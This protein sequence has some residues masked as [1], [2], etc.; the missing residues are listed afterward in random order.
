MDV[1]IIGSGNVATV[2]GKMISKVHKVVHVCS[3]NPEHAAFLAGALHCAFSGLDNINNI[4]AD[5]FL[6]AV[7]DAAI[8]NMAHFHVHEKLVVHTAGSVSMD[9][10]KNVSHNYGIL[11]PLQS[12]RKEMPAPASIPLLIDGNTEENYRAIEAFATTLSADVQKADDVQRLK[13][14]V[15]A[16]IVSNFTNHLYT[17]AEDFCNKEKVDFNLLKPLI[18]ETAQRVQLE[19]PSKLQTGPAVRKDIHTL[20]KHLRLLSNHPK[21]RTT[22][23]RFTDSIMNG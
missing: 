4:K 17:A 13:L 11:Y 19:S 5:L 2:L 6:V 23:L 14:H 20:D 3:R 10:L 7:S 22:Y 12:L 9:S 8:E 21:L 18:L 1:A 15:A 16:V